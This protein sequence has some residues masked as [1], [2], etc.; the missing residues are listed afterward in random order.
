MQIVEQTTTRLVLQKR[1]LVLALSILAFT[2]ISLSSVLCLAA[3]GVGIVLNTAAPDALTRTFSLG[4][5]LLFGA[6]LS[7]LGIAISAGAGRGTTCIFDKDSETFTLR[8]M[9]LLRPQT[10]TQSIYGVSHIEIVRND[11]I[12]VLGMFLVL[13]SGERLVLGTEPSSDG[14]R[15]DT[16]VRHVRHFLKG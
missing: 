9:R 10:I 11:D 13:R 16:L 2:V 7:G 12:G 1:T 6:A 15:V 4:V 5:F 14:E 3:Q 8:K